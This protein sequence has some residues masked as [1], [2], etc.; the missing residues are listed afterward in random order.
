MGDA[1]AVGEL[2]G[3]DGADVAAGADAVAVGDSRS[4]TDRVGLGT[5]GDL[6]A[7]AVTEAVT[8]GV[9]RSPPPSPPQAASRKNMH[10]AAPTRTP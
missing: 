4:P 6:V 1:G 7:L 5:L 2:D 10:A 8:L 3:L 9:G